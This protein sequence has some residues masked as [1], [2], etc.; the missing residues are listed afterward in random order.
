MIYDYVVVDTKLLAYS[1]FH[2]RLP[3]TEF[4]NILMRAIIFNKIKYKKL[5]FAWDVNK[6]RHRLEWFP[7][8]KG[9]RKKNQDKD[10][11]TDQTRREL[12]VKAYKKLPTLLSH[13]GVN[14]NEAIG[15]EADDVVNI[16]HELEPEAKILCISMDWDWLY[17]PM[18]TDKIDVLRFAVNK[19][20]TSENVNEFS[21]AK[22]GLDIEEMFELS[23]IAG[24]SKDSI[25]GINGIGAKRWA[26]HMLPLETKERYELVQTW[27]DTNKY[28]TG[29]HTEGP[30]TIA[31]LVNL[32]TKLM[33]FLTVEDLTEEELKEFTDALDGSKTPEKLSYKD[34]VS[35]S[36][37]E[38][39]EVPPLDEGV[40]NALQNSLHKEK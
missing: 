34:W 35:L 40:Y 37:L 31:D 5:G 22:Y 21:Q 30:D 19:I 10:H 25:P 18:K 36:L 16:I 33:S 39:E 7:G 24:Q 9:G 26:T 14:F 38:L 6:S 12:F 8:Y 32:T 4:L 11:H 29:F 15:M 20:I 3:I 27:L 1:Q 28:K 23:L 13:I 2:R 17:Y